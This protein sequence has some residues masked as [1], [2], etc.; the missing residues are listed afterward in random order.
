[1]SNKD[2]L[3]GLDYRLRKLVGETCDE[4]K[5]YTAP[6]DNPNYG[7]P[8]YSHVTEY[9]YVRIFPFLVLVF[10][11]DHIG[12]QEYTYRLGLLGTWHILTHAKRICS[13]VGGLDSDGQLLQ[14]IKLLEHQKV[15][16]VIFTEENLNL[17]LEFDNDL[18]LGIFHTDNRPVGFTYSE[19]HGYGLSAGGMDYTLCNGE[20]SSEMWMS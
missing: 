3:A 12:S 19:A 7:K 15:K 11:A 20:V 13:Y 14:R 4:I 6:P 9:N 10:G 8:Y 18:W 1:M 16:R 2:N 17:L 5:T